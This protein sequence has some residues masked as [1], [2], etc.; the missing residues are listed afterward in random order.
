MV[1]LA[2]VFSLRQIRRGRTGLLVVTGM[3]AGFLVYFMTNIIYAFGASGGLPILLA[4]WAP[5]LI[6]LMVSS[7]TLLHLEDG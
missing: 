2:S 1:M 5:T 3:V 7:A 4:A 6:L